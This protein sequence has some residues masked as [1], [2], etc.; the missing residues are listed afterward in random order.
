MPNPKRIAAQKADAISFAKPLSGLLVCGA[1][2]FDVAE[3]FEKLQNAETGE[4]T[5]AALPEV[6]WLAVIIVTAVALVASA[7][8]LIINYYS[9]NKT[10]V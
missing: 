1:V 8:L 6:N 10:K 2:I 9:K 4:F 3:I 5:L 7:V